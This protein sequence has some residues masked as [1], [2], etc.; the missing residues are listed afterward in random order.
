MPLRVTRVKP[1]WSEERGGA[2]PGREAAG[3]EVAGDGEAEAA[4][5]DEE[6]NGAAED[7]T[8]RDHICWNF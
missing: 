1:S 5:D 7:E 2:G 3:V 4:E 6:G 8:T